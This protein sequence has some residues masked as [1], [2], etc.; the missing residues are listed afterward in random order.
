MLIDIHEKSLR[1][2][3]RSVML[4]HLLIIISKCRD[5]VNSLIS[6]TIKFTGAINASANLSNT[7]D[8]GTVVFD[9]TIA[10]DS[11]HHL[12]E[13]ID[14]E[15]SA[16]SNS[17]VKRDNLGRIHSVG[18]TYGDTGFKLA[19]GTDVSSLFR[20]VNNYPF[21]AKTVAT[22]D[23]SA[24]NSD[25]TVITNAN[26]SI[27]SSNEVTLTYVNSGLCPTYQHPNCNEDGC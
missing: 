4:P 25:T 9:T 16:V 13:S 24:T 27:N 2:M 22:A 3:I 1:N 19:N 11:H 12:S 8:D 7:N 18:S 21:S 14:S 6:R 10:N 26:L 17:L 23:A 5:K 20:Y 15:V